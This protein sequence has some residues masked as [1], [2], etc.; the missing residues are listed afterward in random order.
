MCFTAVVSR[1]DQVR[2]SPDKHESLISSIRYTHARTRNDLIRKLL[3][4][5]VVRRLAGFSFAVG[6]KTYFVDRIVSGILSFHGWL[7]IGWLFSKWY[8]VNHEGRSTGRNTIH[9]E[10]KSDSLFM[11]VTRHYWKRTGW[12]WSWRDLEASVK[13]AQ[14]PAVLGCSMQDN[15]LKLY[16]A[17]SGACET[18]F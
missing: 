2:C 6:K 10:S 9:H 5:H 4:R 12:K 1:V 13:Q 11:S 16:L 15:I 18:I 8:P 17:V 3:E 14:V 7:G